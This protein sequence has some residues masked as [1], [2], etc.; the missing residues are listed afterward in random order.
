[1]KEQQVQELELQSEHLRRLEPDKEEEIEA[2]R[3]LVAERWETVYYKDGCWVV[4][5]SGTL[6][7]LVDV[8]CFAFYFMFDVCKNLY[9]FAICFKIRFARIQGP[10]MMRRSNLDKVKRIHQ[11]M[12]DVEDEK[13]WIEEMMPRASSQD[14]GNSLL[15]VQLLTKKNHVRTSVLAYLWDEDMLLGI[16]PF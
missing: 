11:F 1:M 3:A 12:R 15:S 14:Y 7:M 4:F 5:F 10:L 13:L 9:S 6:K 8:S 16:G 2:R